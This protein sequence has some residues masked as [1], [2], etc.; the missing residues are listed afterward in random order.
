[1]E[2]YIEMFIE[3]IRNVRKYSDYTET[4]YLIDLEEF[5]NYLNNNKLKFNNLNYNQVVKYTKYL[6][7]EKHLVS[8][9]ISRHLSAIKSFYNFLLEQEIV[10][11]NPFKILSNPKKQIKLPNYM[12]YSE[13]EEMINS[14][15][16]SILGI[17]NKLILEL[18]FA[19]GARVGE[20]VNIK[21]NDIDI[22][23]HE[24]K[25][26]G[27]GN[28]DRIVYFN[29]HTEESLNNYLN[30]S[31]ELLLNNKKSDYLLINHIGTRLTDRGIR[32]IIDKIILKTS[33][34]KKITPHM[35]RHTFATMLLNE[36]CELKSVQELLGHVNLST[37]AIYTHVTNDH[38]K[39]IYLNAHPRGNK[40]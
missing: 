28:K 16:D 2:E 9:S 8:T 38:I 15:D 37:T 17:R 14:I 6:S 34:N 32:D 21:L 26:R 11:S 40:K 31:R 18:L 33:I 13:I 39:D 23:N 30:N 4:N 19:T 36:G 20:V 22:I 12:K 27:K 3:Y 7:E 24:I 5:N 25:V 29:D 35:F 1:M 10:E